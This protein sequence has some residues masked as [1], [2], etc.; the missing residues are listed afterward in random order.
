MADAGAELL[1]SGAETARVEDTMMRLA[2]AYGQSVE[3][4]VFPTA[5]FVQAADG[6]TLLRR[7]QERNVNLAVIAA[8]NQLS[9]RVASE[10]LPPAE[11]ARGLAEAAR[12]ETYRPGRV[13]LAGGAAAAF[14]APLVGGR[15]PDLVPAF[16]A[17]V[18]ALA[19]RNG[20]QARGLRSSLAVLA[21]ALLA[22]LPALAVAAWA[23][24]G[25]AFHPGSILTA[26]MMVLVPG[27]LMT[28][29]VR[30]GIAGDLL[31]SAGKILESLLIAG[32]VAAGAALALALYLKAGGRWP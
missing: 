29:A 18:L 21:A 24:P 11:L 8:V 5:L 1:K 27:V 4:V 32:A 25:V 28:T 13:I 26:G 15:G 6:R 16:L 3:V 2:R 23:P 12:A 22:S 9:R 14:M 19:V 7:V 10:P 30:D 20:L 17:G 31:A